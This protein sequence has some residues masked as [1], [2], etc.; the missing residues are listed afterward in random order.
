[1]AVN[2]TDQS[3]VRQ[4]LTLF[5]DKGVKVLDFIGLPIACKYSSMQSIIQYYLPPFSLKLCGEDLY[6]LE[7]GKSFLTKSK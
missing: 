3:L 6:L 4:L 7:S 5:P 1:M 2:V